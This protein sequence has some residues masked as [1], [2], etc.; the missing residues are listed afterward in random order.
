M[1]RKVKMLM[2]V[3]GEHKFSLAYMVCLLTMF[4]QNKLWPEGIIV[5]IFLLFSFE[6]AKLLSKDILARK[7][8][9]S[10]IYLRYYVQKM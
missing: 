2:L 6:V 10:L 1:T 4:I 9:V 7:R 8:H 5:R 3:L